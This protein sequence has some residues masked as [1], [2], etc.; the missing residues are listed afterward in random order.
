MKFIKYVYNDRFFVMY[1]KRYKNSIIILFRSSQF[2]LIYT[3]SILF[4]SFDKNIG[5]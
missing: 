1:I 3:L 2:S 4:W 5:K